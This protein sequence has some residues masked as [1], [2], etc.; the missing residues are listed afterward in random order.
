M[1]TLHAMRTLRV[2][3]KLP[4]EEVGRVD[5]MALAAAAVARLCL[6]HG[7]RVFLT[8]ASCWMAAGCEFS[9]RA[10]EIPVHGVLLTSRVAPKSSSKVE[11]QSVEMSV[12][13]IWYE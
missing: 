4:W 12:V 13:E 1:A 11:V 7:G 10:F 6:A 8:A 9:S 2:Q 5:G 3:R